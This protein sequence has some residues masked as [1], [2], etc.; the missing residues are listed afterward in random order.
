MG[1]DGLEWNLPSYTQ[2]NLKCVFIHESH[3]AGE[4]LKQLSLRWGPG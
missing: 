3:K 2:G 1:L 4:I